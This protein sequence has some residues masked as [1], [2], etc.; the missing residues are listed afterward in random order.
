M[1]DP[2]SWI[3]ALGISVA[4]LAIIFG[5]AAWAVSRTNPLDKL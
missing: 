2:H 4:V 3:T 1:F 5:I